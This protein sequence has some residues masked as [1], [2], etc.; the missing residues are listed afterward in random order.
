L[1]PGRVKNIL[2]STS[3]RPALGSIQPIQWLPGSPSRCQSG[4]GVMKQTT[5]LQ[6]VPRLRKCGSIHPLPHTPIWCSAELVKLR[7][8]FTLTMTLYFYVHLGPSERASL[9]QLSRSTLR[10]PPE[11][12]DRSSLRNVV[13]FCKTSTYETMDRVQ[14]K[15]NSSELSLLYNGALNTP[16]R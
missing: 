13:V 7:D 14:K 5:H 16:Q 6:L 1:S 8:N 9:N 2:F 12:G 4:R 10:H 15:P 3:S 11:D